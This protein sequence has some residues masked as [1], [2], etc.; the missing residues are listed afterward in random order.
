[1]LLKWVVVIG[2][3]GAASGE[4][5]VDPGSRGEGEDD[6]EVAVCTGHANLFMVSP[7]MTEQ[8]WLLVIRC[9]SKACHDSTWIA[10]L[11][12]RPCRRTTHPIAEAFDR[13]KYRPSQLKVLPKNQAT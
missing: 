12:Y 9:F 8:A 2:R 11:V 7:A 5:T 10:A 13:R 1:M 3:Q 4:S 6:G